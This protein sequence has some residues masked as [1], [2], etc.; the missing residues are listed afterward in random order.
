MK[1]LLQEKNKL[2][3]ILEP[4]DGQYQVQ[5][6]GAGT[7]DYTLQSNFYD[8]Q[9][10]VNFQQFQ[11]ETA[12]GYIAQYN[13]SFD[14]LNS[15][16]TTVELFDEI[17]PEAEI[18]LDSNTQQLEIKG[19]DNTTVHPIVSVDQNDKE[20][21]YQIQDEAGNTTKLYFEKIK[22]EG[23]EIKAELEAI[24]YNNEPIIELPEVEL[25]YE[26][27]LNKDGIIKESEQKIK[28]KDQFDIKAKY[29]HEKNETKIKIKLQN[30]EEQK[31]TLSGIKIIKLITRSGVLEF[32]F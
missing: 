10:Q 12:P 17:P 28:T 30:Q 1:I 24:Q 8:T 2:I 22:K 31:Q 16:S 25:K 14:S 21:I 18:F 3:Q 4:L 9:G 19:M 26:W 13:L 23:K 20:I 7:G 11:S 29:N 27:S 32:E 5:V 6:I 15:A